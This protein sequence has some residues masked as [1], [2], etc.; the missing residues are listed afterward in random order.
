MFSLDEILT[1]SDRESVLATLLALA[2]SFGAPTT[3]WQE[4][5]PIL[6]TLMTDAQKSADL[7]LVAVEIAKGGFGELLPSDAWADLW[8]QS[9]F[10]ET[11]V[12]A[13]SATGYVDAT[14]SEPTNYPFQ[15][16]EFIIAHPTTGKVFRNQ[17]VITI[18][19]S[20][21]LD[22]ILMAADE[23]GTDSNAAPGLTWEIV[24]SAPGVAATNP[25]AF[26]GADRETTPNLVT[27]CRSKLGSF[28]PNGPKDVYDFVAKTP[29][30]SATSVPITR[31]KTVLDSTTG[32][33]TTYLATDAGAPISGDVDIVQDA[34]DQFAEPW[35]ATAIAAA[36]VGVPIAITYQAWVQGTQLTNAQIQTLIE[37][38]L[39][40]WFKSLDIG[41]YVIPP[42]DGGVYPDVLEQVIGQATPGIIRVA[43]TIPAAF[44]PLDVSEVATLSTITPTITRLV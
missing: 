36:S 12:P 3:A 37:A 27:R 15:P 2:A 40:T 30:Y 9:R 41:G 7:T 31:T 24:S 33:I 6:T 19:A 17:E 28:S 11:R 39:I 8:A 26:I 35:G 4:G 43:V 25:L 22:D 23:P 21:G 16:G 44:V 1:P 42:D 34:F 38:A 32:E 18:L 29:L 20:A 5:D 13:E 10:N 14:N